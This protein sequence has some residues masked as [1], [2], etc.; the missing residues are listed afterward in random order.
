MPRRPMRI[1]SSVLA[2]TP[3]SRGIGLH[4]SRS[5]GRR[6]ALCTQL[7]TRSYRK[8]SSPSS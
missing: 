8:T 6:V 7:M 2:A 5:I 4:S 3:F 1:P